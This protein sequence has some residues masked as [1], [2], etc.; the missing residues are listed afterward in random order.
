[1]TSRA[2]I[3]QALLDTGLMAIL[4]APDAATLEPVA[5]ALA[6]AGVRCLEVT[7]TGSGALDVVGRLRAA[8]PAEVLRRS[9][10]GRDRRPGPGRCRRGCRVPGVSCH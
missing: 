7:L 3:P 1:M 6:D 9:R 5:H 2:A 8:L 10:D 4:R